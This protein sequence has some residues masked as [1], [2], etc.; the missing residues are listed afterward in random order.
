VAF[1]GQNLYVAYLDTRQRKEPGV[2]PYYPNVHLAAF[3]RNWNL[4]DDEAV[5][6]VSF[7]DSLFAG[8]PW[9]LLHGNRLYV[10]YDVV[11]LPEDLSR[12]EVFVSVYEI[13][14]VIPSVVQPEKTFKNIQLGQNYPNPCSSLTEIPFSLLNKEMATLKVYDIQG[15]EVTVLVNEVKQPGQYTVIFDTKELQSGIYFYKIQAGGLSETKK[16]ILLK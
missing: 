15:R 2:F 12:I 7:S 13:P 16:L 5:T 4:L 11:P 14:Q 9:V 3:D 10:S 6:D 1:D 8:R